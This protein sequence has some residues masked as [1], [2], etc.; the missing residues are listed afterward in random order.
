MQRINTKKIYKPFSLD[1]DL[2]IA[3]EDDIP[4][5]AEICEVLGSEIRLGILKYLQS[6]PYIHS[7]PTLVKELG[8][9]KTTILHHLHKMENA[10]IINMFYKSSEHGLVRFVGRGLKS[11]NI[12]IYHTETSAERPVVSEFQTLGVGQFSDF[13]GDRLSLATETE[14]FDNIADRCFIPQ[15]FEAQLIYM[16]QG[17]IS[18]FFNKV[19]TQKKLAEL[20]LSLEICSE[21]PYFD[22]T[23]KSDIT[24][25][26]NGRETATFQCDGDYGD[27]RGKLNPEWWP[28]ANTQYGK[29]LTLSVRTDGVFINGNR[30]LSKVKLS[31]LHLK[32]GN[33]ISIVIGNK[34]TA[35]YPNGFNLFGREF[36]DYPQDICL[37]FKYETD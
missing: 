3:R 31:D 4:I 34:D 23:Y 22:N 9:P 35:E 16:P 24:F 5:I 11:A 6:P 33:K 7:L 19:S 17:T 12:V 30:T 27:R 37:E 13:T 36:G 14:L 28:S 29:L 25:W 8:I 2:T 26:I 18:Y 10:G 32:E 1:L 21:A 20:N 15:R